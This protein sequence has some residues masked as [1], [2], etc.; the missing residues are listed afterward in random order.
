MA[1]LKAAYDEKLTQKE[2]LKGKAKHMELMMD[3]AHRLVKGLSAERIRW[4]QTVQVCVFH[5][6]HGGSC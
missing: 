3:R 4:M 1:E 2:V 5:F 6:T